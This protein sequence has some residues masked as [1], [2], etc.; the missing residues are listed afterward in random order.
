MIYF[1]K[2][3]YIFTTT[4]KRRHATTTHHSP[5]L[6]EVRPRNSNMAGIRRQELKRPRRSCFACSVYFLIPPRTTIPHRVGLSTS[7]TKEMPYRPA[8]S[9]ILQRHFPRMPRNPLAEVTAQVPGFNYA[10]RDQT[11]G[12]SRWTRERC[13]KDQAL[14]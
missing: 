8:F 7:I 6:P 10:S 13:A 11:R 14:L 12:W 9:L 1:L 2:I 4:V 3:F 5:S